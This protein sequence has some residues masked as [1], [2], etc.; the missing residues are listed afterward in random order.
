M[1]SKLYLIF[2]A[3]CLASCSPH[4]TETPLSS[5]VGIWQFPERE[6]WLEVNGDGHV[7]QCRID[8]NG[9]VI[10]STGMFKKGTISWQQIWE[11]DHVRREGGTLYLKGV[12]GDF[13]FVKPIDQM[14]E[15]CQNPIS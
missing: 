8:K 13:G 6:V 3:L 10:E 15:K 4:Q 7:Y 5:V 12:H 1:N 11:K 9:S 14:V 2:A